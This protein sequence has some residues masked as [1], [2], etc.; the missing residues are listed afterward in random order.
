M[1][2]VSFNKLNHQNNFWEKIKLFVTALMNASYE[3]YTEI[4]KLLLEQNEVNINDKD[5]YLFNSMIIL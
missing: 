4:V 2:N 5:A 1:S 3:G